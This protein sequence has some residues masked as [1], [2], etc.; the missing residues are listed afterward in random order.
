M[1]L[2]LEYH[3][4]IPNTTTKNLTILLQFWFNSDVRLAIPFGYVNGVPFDARTPEQK[5]DAAISRA[6]HSY[7]DETEI[8]IV[9]VDDPDEFPLIRQLFQTPSI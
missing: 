5:R 7:D 8:T 2:L 4:E 9:P 6:L 3:P 1:Q